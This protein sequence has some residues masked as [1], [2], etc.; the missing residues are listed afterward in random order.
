MTRTAAAEDPLLNPGVVAEREVHHPDTPFDSA[1]MM[2]EGQAQAPFG[3]PT[4]PISESSPGPKVKITPWRVLNTVLLLVLGMYKAVAAYRGQQTAPT[5]LDWILGVLWAIIA[6]WAAFLEEAQLGP[7]GRWFFMHDLSGALQIALGIVLGLIIIFGVSGVLIWGMIAWKNIFLKL[8]L[9]SLLL[10]WLRTIFGTR[11]AEPTGR[12]TEEISVGS[13]PSYGSLS[14]RATTASAAFAFTAPTAATTAF[15]A[16]PSALPAGV[17]L[18]P[19][20]VDPPTSAGGVFVAPVING[21]DIAATPTTRYPAKEVRLGPG[22]W[23][24]N[25]TQQAFTVI[26]GVFGEQYVWLGVYIRAHR[27]EAEQ[28][29]EPSWIACEFATEEQARWFATEFMRLRTPPYN[30]LHAIHNITPLNELEQL[31]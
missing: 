1:A 21:N 24:R 9:F 2:E 16:T 22:I 8:L 3:L 12:N 14:P 15:A 4:T 29:D 30:T 20:A 7:R 23:G 11:T 31:V 19:I 26:K 28:T 17:A 25:L 13:G 18:A 6:Y 5:T 10:L 27:L